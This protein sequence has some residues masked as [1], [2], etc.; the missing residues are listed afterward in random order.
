MLSPIFEVVRKNKIHSYHQLQ[1]NHE[2][3]EVSLDKE[4]NKINY[5]F[6]KKP[7]TANNKIVSDIF[8]KPI[9]AAHQ[10]MYARVGHKFISQDTIK[11]IK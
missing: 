5:I 10:T 6:E 1:N 7:K 2:N 8:D 9:K 4:T 3:E 11:Q